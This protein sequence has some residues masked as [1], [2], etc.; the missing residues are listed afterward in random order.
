MRVFRFL[1]ALG[2]MTLLLASAISQEKSEPD[3]DRMQAI[4]VGVLNRVN[5]QNDQWFE[6]GDYPRCIQSL[7][8][9][10]EIYPTD[11]DVASSLGWLLE[12]T[13]QDAEALAVYV[14]FRLENPADPEAPFPEA[15]YY[16]MKRAY[17]LVPPLLEPVIHMALKP[18]PNTFRR[19]AHAYERL[20]LL[21]DSKRVWEQLI[22]LTPEDEAAKANL[23]RVLRKIKGELDPP[24][25]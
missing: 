25:R 6:I 16:F 19:L 11:Y 21:A 2:A 23:Q 20:G 14:R 4:L 12:S 15:N 10:H 1:S 8:V 17:A 24:K 3:Q 5:H 18:H 7:R 22:K 13:D 9:L